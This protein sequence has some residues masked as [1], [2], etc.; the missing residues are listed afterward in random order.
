MCGHHVI[1]CFRSRMA[2]TAE[3]FS[4]GRTSLHLSQSTA[5]RLSF[6]LV[7]SICKDQKNPLVLRQRGDGMEIKGK[8]IMKT[9]LIESALNQEN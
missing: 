8:G 1:D 7:D 9:W 3:A 6:Q 2:S 5:E 4:K